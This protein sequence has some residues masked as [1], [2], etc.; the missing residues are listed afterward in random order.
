M[1]PEVKARLLVWL[2]LLGASV[3]LSQFGIAFA[4]IPLGQE[5]PP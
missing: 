3:V 2:L 4:G 5:G 1:S